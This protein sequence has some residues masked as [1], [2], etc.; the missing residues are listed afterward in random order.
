[1]ASEQFREMLAVEIEAVILNEGRKSNR[2][3]NFYKY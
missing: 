3:V 2:W 1:M